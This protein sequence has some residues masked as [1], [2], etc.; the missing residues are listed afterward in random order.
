M[1]SLSVISLTWN[2]L[3]YGS[4]LVLR[5]GFLVQEA[6]TPMSQ[7]SDSNI[8]QFGC[9]VEQLL[10]KRMSSRGDAEVAAALL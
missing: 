8:F 3:H 6:L 1:S 10:S 4:V 2:Y 9:F 7:Q 5:F